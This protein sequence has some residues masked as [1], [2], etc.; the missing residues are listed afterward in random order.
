MYDGDIVLTPYTVGSCWRII[1]FGCQAA[2]HI[3]APEER[4]IH[5]SPKYVARG[6]AQCGYGLV[7][8]LK[9]REERNYKQHQSLAT[10]QEW[11]TLMISQAFG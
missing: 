1:V 9:A 10:E 11:Q 6:F 7:I 3:S 8:A 2:A 5:I 4:Q